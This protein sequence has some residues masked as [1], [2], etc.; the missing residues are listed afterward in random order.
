MAKFVEGAWIVIIAAPLLAIFFMQIHRHYKK[1]SR[2]IETP[3]ELQISQ[4]QPPI[5]IIPIHGWDRIA[6]KAVRFGLLL[7]DDVTAIY[8][9]TDNEKAENEKL[10]KRWVDKVQKPAKKAGLTIPKITIIYSPYRRIYQP[11]LDFVNKIKKEKPD[12][13][14][15]VVIPEL[16]E[17]H[18]YEYLLHN[19]HAA[20][21]RAFLFLERDQRTV[22]I[23][24]PWYIHEKG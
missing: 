19:I 2:V 14:I 4:L 20:G 12:R 24:T 7:S 1:I 23:T 9:S 18:W 10:Q 17:A 15:A 13:L 3:L 5:V 16:V 11:I 6:E 22:V 8:V 21:L